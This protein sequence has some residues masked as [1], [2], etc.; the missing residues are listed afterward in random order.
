MHHNTTRIAT[1]ICVLL[2]FFL[3]DIASVQAT[4]LLGVRTRRVL[5][6]INPL[7]GIATN[8]RDT[9][10][11]NL[12]GISFSPNGV[13]YGL[14]TFGVLAP[15]NSLFT[16]EPG[17]GASTLIGPT[18]L[19]SIFE[20]DLDFDPQSGILYAIQS[21]PTGPQRDLFTINTETGAATT[22]GSISDS[23]DLSAM[24]FSDSGTLYVLDTATELLLTV[25]P[26][27]A[28][29]LTSVP[30]SLSL[31]PTA[32]MD[33]DPDTGELYVADGSTDGTNSLYTLDITTG[34]LTL[35][36][37]TGLTSGLSGL[38]FVPEPSALGLA[39]FALIGF[40]LTNRTRKQVICVC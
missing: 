6:D 39:A 14:T 33:F 4:P 40:L 7:T 38:E 35:I 28:S 25:D 8:P 17:T 21:V 32:G 13:L 36:G 26:S 29:L 20:G 1:T 16:I 34:E 18:G 10:I 12:A 23:G 22:V 30:L 27:T 3:I 37:S 11:E 19:S 31:G 5:Y 9:G 2:S 24:A 15:P